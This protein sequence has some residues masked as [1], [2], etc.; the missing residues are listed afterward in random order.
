MSRQMQHKEQDAGHRRDNRCLAFAGHLITAAVRLLVNITQL[1]PPDE[2]NSISRSLQAMM[3]LLRQLATAPVQS[4]TT[5]TNAQQKAAVKEQ[6]TKT[7]P[8]PVLPVGVAA[9]LLH[10]VQLLSRVMLRVLKETEPQQQQQ[11]EPDINFSVA[12][13]KLYQLWHRCWAS[14]E[15]Y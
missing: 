13:G 12:A 15:N 2:V 11:T 9:G 10:L 14:M 8:I 3:L 6:A 7:F 5:A 1:L 4:L